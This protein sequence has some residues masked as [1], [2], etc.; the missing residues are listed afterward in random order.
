MESSPKEK[1]KQQGDEWMKRNH[2]LELTQLTSFN[3]KRKTEKVAKD[4][5]TWLRPVSPRSP[6]DLRRQKNLDIS[7][8]IQT[9]SLEISDYTHRGNW[10]I[11]RSKK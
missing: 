7:V 3:G 6:G 1:E 10:F 4:A 2:S 5:T 11:L 9:G 8:E